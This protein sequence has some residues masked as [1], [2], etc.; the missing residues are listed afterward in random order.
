M[1]VGSHTHAASVARRVLSTTSSRTGPPRCNLST[2]LVRTEYF[3]PPRWRCERG[4]ERERACFRSSCDMSRGR[5]REE[6]EHL[7]K[8]HSRSVL[9]FQFS[10]GG[11][12]LYSR[13]RV[14]RVP[15]MV[16]RVKLHHTGFDVLI[17][18][19]NKKGPVAVYLRIGVAVQSVQNYFT[20]GPPS[21]NLPDPLIPHLGGV[22]LVLY[23]HRQ[24]SASLRH[25]CCSHS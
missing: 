4:R 9:F 14:A 23:S 24:S 10:V 13:S 17:L 19:K 6:R 18:L 12:V 1:L 22:T 7:L 3:S 2:E 16:P 21:C 15:R 8:R 11:R 20:R 25:S 5:E